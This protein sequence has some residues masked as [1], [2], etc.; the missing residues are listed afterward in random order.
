MSESAARID[1]SRKKKTVAARRA[2]LDAAAVEAKRIS[3]D[4]DPAD[5]TGT[6]KHLLKRLLDVIDLRS[7]WG[8]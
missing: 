8:A 1:T 4:V 3:Q 6:Q 2:L 7:E 5:R